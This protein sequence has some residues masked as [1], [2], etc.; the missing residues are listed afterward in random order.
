M[1]Q[2]K[3]RGSST[4][5]YSNM[6][7]VPAQITSTYKRRR[8]R[9]GQE[10]IGERSCGTYKLKGHYSTICPRNSNRNRAIEKK[11]PSRGV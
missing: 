1:P 9:D 10:I 6:G 7:V 3:G 2:M 11:V 5:K 8:G 4:G